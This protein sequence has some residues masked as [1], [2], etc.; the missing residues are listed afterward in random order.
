MA[1]NPRSS[2]LVRFISG[3]TVAIGQVSETQ[4]WLVKQRKIAGTA[5]VGGERAMEKVVRDTPH[6]LLERQVVGVA[7]VPRLFLFCHGFVVE[8]PA[9][10]ACP[11]LRLRPFPAL[12]QG[13]SQQRIQLLALVSALTRERHQT[14]KWGHGVV[15]IQK[16]SDEIPVQMMRSS[17]GSILCD[18]FSECCKC[19]NA[20]LQQVLAR[21]AGIIGMDANTPTEG[22]IHHNRPECVEEIIKADVTCIAQSKGRG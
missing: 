4:R 14:I 2:T 9:L 7:Y 13:N 20:L 22:A 15:C 1:P 17:A 18:A 12:L 11:H 21:I 10:L 6:V 8:G 19:I 16:V 3:E 5:L